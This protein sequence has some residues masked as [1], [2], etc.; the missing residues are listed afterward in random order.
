MKIVNKVWG[1]ERWIINNNLYC[2][3]ELHV[4]ADCTCS[5]HYHKVKDETFVMKHGRI[6]L[7]H[8]SKLSIFKPGEIVRVKP[9]EHHKF[10]ACE[11][12]MMIEVSTHHD[13]RD[14]YRLTES[15]GVEG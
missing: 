9:G 5:L 11:D 4:K 2:M 12:S 14:S 6:L 1:T 8:N 7:L 3:K 13:D 15:K 10:H